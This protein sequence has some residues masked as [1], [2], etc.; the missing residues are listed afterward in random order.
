MINF[1]INKFKNI[2]LKV[3]NIMKYGFIF[4]LLFCFISILVLYTYHQIY[5]I[6]LL[7]TI[8]TILFKTSLMF[9]VDFTICGMAFDSIKKQII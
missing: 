1:I 8:G 7:F 2:D 5:T 3:K 6:P 4:S 9:F